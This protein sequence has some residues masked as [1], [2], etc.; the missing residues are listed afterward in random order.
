MKLDDIAVGKGYEKGLE[1]RG[2]FGWY[3]RWYLRRRRPIEVPTILQAVGGAPYPRVLDAG[4]GTGL[5]LADVYRRGH[6]HESLAGVD[7]S[8]MMAQETRDR[9]GRI[10]C[11]DTKV[12]IENCSAVELPFA[13]GSFDLVMANAMVK[14][15]DD[16]PF[17]RFLAEAYRV[18]SPG[19][20]IS[21]WD[22]GRPLFN[23]PDVKVD[24]PALEM[25]NLRTSEVLMQRLSEAG[26]TQT[27]PYK[28]RRPWRMPVTFEGAVATR[29]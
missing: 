15:L 2:P 1:A 4:C 3:M 12:Q 23:L 22:F 19:G 20:R 13:D 6:G 9:L 21:L 14:H 25:K 7:V 24:N 18:L 27:A 29:E 26:F 5:W 28:V 8:E 11:P 17:A 10:A 16:G